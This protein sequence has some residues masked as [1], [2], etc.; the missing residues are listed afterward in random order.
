MVRS[1]T[2]RQVTNQLAG[3]CNHSPVACC[4][5]RGRNMINSLAKCDDLSTIRWC[6]CVRAIGRFSSNWWFSV[7]SLYFYFSLSFYQVDLFS[8]IKA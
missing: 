5:I 1:G 3:K 6:A 4:C 8:Y 2:I 7:F